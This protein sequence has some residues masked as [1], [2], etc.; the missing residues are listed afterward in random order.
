MEF[1][2]FYN[3]LSADEQMISEKLG[4][5]QETDE[6][7]KSDKYLENMRLIEEKKKI[8]EARDILEKE[9]E[10]MRKKATDE[11]HNVV[12]EHF[13]GDSN[14]IGKHDTDIINYLSQNRVLLFLVFIL[15]ICCFMQYWNQQLMMEKINGMLRYA[16]TSQPMPITPVTSV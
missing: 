9:K 2:N 1:D 12:R 14:G 4:Y 7:L 15:M 16:T 13:V 11:H 10:E 5:L 3:S 6:R 8:Q